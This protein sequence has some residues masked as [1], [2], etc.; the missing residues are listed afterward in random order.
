MSNSTEQATMVMQES[1]RIIEDFTVSKYAIYT[2]LYL[3]EIGLC[4]YVLSKM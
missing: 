2:V 3:I 4:F 1:N